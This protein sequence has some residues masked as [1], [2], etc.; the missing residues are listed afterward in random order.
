M[1]NSVRI[2]VGPFITGTR[3]W[4]DDGSLVV[5]DPENCAPE[6]SGTMKV[7]PDGSGRWVPVQTGLEIDCKTKKPHDNGKYLEH[8][9]DGESLANHLQLVQNHLAPFLKHMMERYDISDEGR[10]N[11]PFFRIE[12]GV[13]VWDAERV[14][15]SQVSKH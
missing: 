9:H 2:Y 5:M 6:F 7:L 10:E 8:C 13:L 11:R 15:A 14:E 3:F 12:W 4:D 1:S